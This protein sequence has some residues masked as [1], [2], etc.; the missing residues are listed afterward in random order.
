MRAG[1]PAPGFLSHGRRRRACAAGFPPPGHGR[2]FRGADFEKLVPSDKKL[3]PE[4]VKSLFERGSPE[5]LRGDDL[6]FVGMPVGGIGAGQLYLGG[7]GRL[8]H[9]DVFNQHI[10]TG[11]EH[12]AR[13]ITPSSPLK[14]QFTLSVRSGNLPVGSRRFSRNCFSRRISDWPGG[15]LQAGPAGGRDARSIFTI[16]PAEHRRLQPA[17]NHSSVHAA[18]HLRLT[19]PGHPFRR[20]GK[21]RLPEPPLAGR[22]P[23]QSRSP[24]AGPDYAALLRRKACLSA[25]APARHCF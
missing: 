11:A 18:K 8:W 2:P 10:G 22:S 16:R 4:W 20:N 12:Y 24:R 1:N 17:G 9:W 14:Q 6:K 19:G 13:P 7:D 25:S 5:V 21:W 3:R 23:A 15:I